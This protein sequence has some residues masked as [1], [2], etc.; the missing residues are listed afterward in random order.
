MYQ[1][2]LT[3][4]L[5]PIPA[6]PM[7]IEVPELSVKMTSARCLD[8]L[9]TKRQSGA[10][11][12]CR[13]RMLIRITDSSTIARNSPAASRVRLIPASRRDYVSI[14]VNGKVV[15]EKFNVC[16]RN[17]G[18]GWRPGDPGDD[19]DGFQRL[20]ASLDILVHNLKRNSLL[21][22]E[23]GCCKGLMANPTLDGRALTGWKIYLPCPWTIP[24]QLPTS[25][26]TSAATGPTFFS[27]SS[28]YQ[29]PR[30][31]VF[32]QD[33]FSFRCGLG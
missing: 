31:N 29:R 3:Y 2:S 23:N 10:R 18:R 24:L 7:V 30:R 21:T 8:R 26:K 33:S 5:P 15:G 6:D 32:G 27:G 22:S 20:L 17:L 11:T 16:R 28:Q 13:W 4:G 14:M 12:S 25:T 1:K 19:D 9:P